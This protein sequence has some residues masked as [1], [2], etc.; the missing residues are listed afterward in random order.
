MRITKIF[1]KTEYGTTFKAEAYT[2]DGLVWRWVSNNSV[3]PLDAAQQ[4]GIPVNEAAQ[5]ETR[6]RENRAF[7][8]EYRQR[9]AKHVPSDEEMYEMRAA[10]GPGAKVVNVVTGR[11]TQL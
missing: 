1:T 2:D 11:I 5:I 3:C 7:L 6:D 8:E 9:M 4:Y 10:F